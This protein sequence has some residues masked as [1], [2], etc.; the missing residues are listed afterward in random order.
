MAKASYNEN[1]MQM[2]VQRQREPGANRRHMGYL[3]WIDFKR[4]S[5][6]IR[7]E[8]ME[9]VWFAD[10]SGFSSDAGSGVGMALFKLGNLFLYGSLYV[11]LMV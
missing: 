5:F 4:K 2:A 3:G 11:V 9:R 10:E 7:K 8:R 1:E 6:Y